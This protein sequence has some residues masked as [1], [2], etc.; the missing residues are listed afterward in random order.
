MCA[1]RKIVEMLKAAEAK[2]E[3]AAAEFARQLYSSQKPMAGFNQTKE[4]WILGK[5]AEV[6]NNHARPDLGGPEM[7]WACSNPGG[8]GLA[9]FSVYDSNRSYLRDVEV[10]A[11]F[12]KPSV[13][14]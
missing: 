3:Q 7:V 10:T 12:P 9:D 6:Y 4:D 5:F 11:L 2:D 1:V 14:K 13:K 8:S